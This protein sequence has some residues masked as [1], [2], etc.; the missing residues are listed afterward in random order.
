[1]SKLD[2]SNVIRVTIL[3]ALRGLSDI[4]TSALAIFTDEAPI[5]GDYGTSGVYLN[6]SGVADDF[7]SNS[8][9][10]SL[11]QTI[12]SQ[13]PNILTGGGYLVVIPR[14][15]SALAQPATI[16]GKE[17]ID[18]TSL[19]ATDFNI[20]LDID[21]GGAVD[22]AIGEIDTTSISTALISLNNT[23]I[24][25]AGV[26]FEISGSL[27]TAIITLKTIADGSSKTIDIGLAGTGTDLPTLLKLSGSA[28]GSDAGV[29]RV[30]DAIL[31]TAGSVNYFGIVLN[32]KQSDVNLLELAATVQT[33][34]KLLFV[35]S[36][37]S[38]DIE[39]VFS[40]VLNRGYTHTRCLYYSVSENDALTFAAGYGSRGLSTNF[41][42]S[43]TAQTMHLKEIVGLEG[44]AG[45]TQTLLTKCGSAGVDS[46]VD[47][48]V[49]KLFTSGANKYFDQI[50]SR[51][52][53]KVKLQIAGFNFLA[54]TNSKIPQTEEGMN[55]L[56]STYRD[57]LSQFV[58]NGTFAPGTWKGSTTFG[59]PADHIRNIADFGYY[60]YSLPLS[61]QSQTQRDAR[62]APLIQC[63]GKDSGAIHSS[64]VTVL[65][66]A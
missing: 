19:N 44:D 43:D 22:I 46:Y 39:G 40:S 59:N 32:E 48:G 57:V 12:F 10:Y 45:M 55:A 60:I 38:A 56:K 51:L 35:G 26:K 23:A 33:L 9:T 50:Y 27:A 13:N 52:A 14:N 5:P 66:E 16:V 6:A 1:M 18:L 61:K 7:G 4:N 49:P 2:I 30:K 63:A 8:D 62:V 36:N 17:S 65:V 64:D 20:N 28:T 41:N 37:L 15:Q 3:S 34:D 29:E 25:N 58:T 11:A 42:G 53:L 31:R 21:S 47:F 54:Q 24:T